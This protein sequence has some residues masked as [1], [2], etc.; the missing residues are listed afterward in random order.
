MRSMLDYAI[1]K[2]L[3]PYFDRFMPDRA[4]AFRARVLEALRR[5]PPEERQ[6]LVLT[7]SGTVE[8][9][10]SRADAIADPRLKDTL[11]QRAVF[12]A[13][14]GDDFEQA[15]ALIERLSNEGGRSNARNILRQ[16]MDEKRS[17]DAWSALNKGDFRRPKRSPRSF[18]TGARMACWCAALLAS[19]PTKINRV[20]LEYSMNMSG[21]PRASRSRVKERCG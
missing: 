7:E 18:Q 16:R 20:L 4:P 2:L 9:L 14:Y 13:S 19:C 6:Y 21:E 8:E 5:V 11:I 10:L 15:S 1:P 17:N 12:Q 3:V